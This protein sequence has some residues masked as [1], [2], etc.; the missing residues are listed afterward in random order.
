MSYLRHRENKQNV[1]VL[2]INTYYKY[3]HIIIK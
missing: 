3:K 1:Y 2:N